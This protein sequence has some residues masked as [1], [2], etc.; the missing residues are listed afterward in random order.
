MNLLDQLKTRNIELN[1]QQEKAVQSINGATLLLAV[2][3]SGK[4]TVIITR[5]GNMIYNHKIDPN[6][7]LTLTFSVAAAS[8]MKN[9]F[10]EIYGTEH[11]SQLQ[12]RTIHSFCLIIIREYEKMKGTKAFSIIENNIQIIKRIYFEKYNEYESEETFQTV[13][14]KISNCKN[15]MLSKEQIRNIKIPEYDLYDIYDKYES[16]KKNNKIMDFDDV[17]SYAYVILKNYPSLLLMFQDRFK[18]INVDEAQDTSL[19]QHEIIRLLVKMN[20]NIFMVGDEDQCIYGFRA[21]LPEE[22]L[23]F[24]NNYKEAQVLK[25][26]QNFRST[27]KIVEAANKFIKENKNRFD[28]DMFC[29]NVEGDEIKRTFISDYYSQSKTIIN[30]I[31]NSDKNST[32]AILY[33]NNESAIPLVNSLIAENIPFS[34]KENSTNFFTHFIVNDIKNFIKVALDFSDLKSFQRI[35][36][37]MKY[38]INK[39]MMEFVIENFDD[40]IFETLYNYPSLKSSNIVGIANMED[41]FKKIRSLTPLQA[42]EYIVNNM[43][44]KYKSNSLEDDYSLDP[45]YQKIRI[46]LSIAKDEVSLSSFL[47]KLSELENIMIKPLNNDRKLVLTT[48]HSSKGLEFDK[49]ML[50]DLIDGIF[51]TLA[52]IQQKNDG[53]NDLYE[54]ERR[55]FYVAITRAK[56]EL[57]LFIP[58]NSDK[59]KIIHSQI[60]RVLFSKKEALKEEKKEKPNYKFERVVDYRPINENSESNANKKIQKFVPSADSMI[61]EFELLFKSVDN[62]VKKVITQDEFKKYR[63]GVKITHKMYGIGTIGD[64]Y[65]G[66]SVQVNFESVGKKKILLYA[67]LEDGTVELLL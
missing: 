59:Y 15:L 64:S 39:P 5:I 66:G 43:G 2:P 12:F 6:Q 61:D 10:V 53:L 38:F 48:I 32:L 24:K 29:V 13:S 27:K 1:P 20:N 16:Y 7:I 44:Y 31:K 42:I 46:L 63:P 23:N 4:T 14:Q 34:I 37:K 50:I 45:L 36:Y 56:K 40:S 65:G 9:R 28:K 52:S 30:S 25:M 51:P 67:C 22:L 17:L 62:T 3:G 26:E 55:L 54:E 58:N 11:A 21:A 19:I 41:A 35:Y 8:D 57:E 18:Y 60:T 49:V 33:R 47:N